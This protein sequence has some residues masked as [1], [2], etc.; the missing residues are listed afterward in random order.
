MNNQK[1][2][3]R[4]QFSVAEQAEIQ[5][6]L[7]RITA[8][9][10]IAT[11]EGNWVAFYSTLSNIASRHLAGNPAGL[12]T[13][14]LQHMQNLKLWLDVAI[15]ANGNTGM[16]STFIRTFTTTQA[17][18]RIGKD[19]DSDLMQLASNGVAVNLKNG[20]VLDN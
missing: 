14:N 8:N 2:N 3:V 15:G 1:E 9:I 19:I 18:L 12:S 10:D 11:A 5:A 6:S 7:T 20:A 16:H 17:R 4:Y 13:I